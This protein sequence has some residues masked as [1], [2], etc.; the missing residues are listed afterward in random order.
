[1]AKKTRGSNWPK[2]VEV[3]G[4]KAKV[5]RVTGQTTASGTAYVTAW[6]TPAGRQ[7]KKFADAADAI[8][9]ARLQAGKIAAGRAE[10]G[11]MTRADFEEMA[12]AKA[13]TGTVPLLA[14]LEEWREARELTAGHVI[15]ACEAW[16]ARNGTAFESITLAEASKRFLAAKVASKVSVKKSYGR[17]FPELLKAFGERTITSLGAKELQAWMEKRFPHPVTR[18]TVR[19]RCVTL[20]RWARKKNYLPRDVQSEAELTDTAQEPIAEIGIISA[21]TFS[22]LLHFFRARHSEYLAALVLAAF[23]GLRRAELHAQVWED[24]DLKAGHLKVTSAKAN[25][26]AK[27]LVPLSPAAVQWLMLTKERKGIVCFNQEIHR[28][29]L[30][31]DRIRD[32]ART[33]NDEEGKPLFPSLPENCFRHA[34]ISHRVAQTGNVAETALEMGNSPKVIFAHY[35]ALVSKAEGSKWFAIAPT[36]QAEGEVIDMKEEAVGA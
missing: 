35:R 2:T 32:I 29:N 19:K 10:A 13:I 16:A 1:M 28:V 6:R 9:E 12:A 23:A 15:T 30:A 33:A 7:T 22:R 18:N 11:L 34:C 17:V 26:P 4:V 36:P 5:Y 14:A 24:I 20:W 25:T 8:A 21:D 31:I 3:G 27:R